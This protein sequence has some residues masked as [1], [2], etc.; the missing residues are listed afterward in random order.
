MGGVPSSA[1][2]RRCITCESVVRMRLLDLAELEPSPSDGGHR[3]L[4]GANTLRDI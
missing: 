1:A 3:E 2:V 4:G